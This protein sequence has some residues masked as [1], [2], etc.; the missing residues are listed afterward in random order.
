MALRHGLRA[1]EGRTIEQGPALP[2]VYRAQHIQ[3]LCGHTTAC[4]LHR[5]DL[6][7][8]LLFVAGRSLND[9]HHIQHRPPL[10]GVVHHMK[11]VAQP[12]SDVK[13]AEMRRQRLHG[14]LCPVGA[15]SRCM[16]RPVV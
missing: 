10:D 6:G 8:P 1:M 9:D 15:M 7:Q 13:T 12:N 14:Q 11:L 3:E 16:R 5:C 2:I 4:T